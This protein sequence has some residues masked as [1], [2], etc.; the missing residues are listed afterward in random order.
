MGEQFRNGENLED[1]TRKEISAEW[2]NGLSDEELS[3]QEMTWSASET[4]R[5]SEEGK[6]YIPALQAE[7]K[8]RGLPLFTERAKDVEGQISD[9][10]KMG[11]EA[12]ENQEA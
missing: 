11:K 1:P 3:R 12:D 4:N 9:V 2:I 5:N 6:V 8:R 7:M 10:A